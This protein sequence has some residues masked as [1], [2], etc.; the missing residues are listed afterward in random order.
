[1]AP[2]GAHIYLLSMFSVF[3]QW[4]ELIREAVLRK[5]EEF[6]CISLSRLA[7]ASSSPHLDTAEAGAEERPERGRAANEPSATF[8]QSTRRP[9]PG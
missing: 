9:S 7:L 4:G 3:R 1:M 8:S 2:I 5:R 6:G